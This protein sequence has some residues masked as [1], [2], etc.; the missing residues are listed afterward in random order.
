MCFSQKISATLF[1]IGLISTYIAY[2]SPRLRSK[3]MHIL[4][5]FYTLMELLQTVQYSYVNECNNKCN[6]Y[7]TEVAYILVIVQPLL[8]N[9]IFY[10]RARHKYRQI[11][12]TAMILSF[13]WILWNIYSRIDY[14][15]DDTATTTQTSIFASKK[16]CTYRD[17]DGEHLYWKW[18]SRNFKDLSANYFMYLCLWL[19][20]I[21]IDPDQWISGL[22]LIISSLVGLFLTLKYGKIEEFAA[23]WCYIS[24]P[25][26]L[27]NFIITSISN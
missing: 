1:I 26:F 2:K 27:V 10:L 12:I 4:L 17:K 14:K 7:L 8:W 21:L 16:S 22:S 13:V 9:Y 19:L 15:N 18:P 23:I 5:A 25:T 20:P 3:Y 6:N 11:F 24:I